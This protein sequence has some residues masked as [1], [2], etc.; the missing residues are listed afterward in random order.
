VNITHHNPIPG[1][2]KRV[3]ILGANGF[4]ARALAQSLA[5][6]DIP[7]AVIGSAQVDLLAPDA[8]GKLSALLKPDDALVIT[9]ALTPEKGKDVRTFMKNITMVE[10]VCAALD[11]VRCSQ[12]IYLSSDAVYDDADPLVRETT[13]RTGL[14]LYGLMHVAREQ[15]LGFV[16]A[17]KTPIPLCLVRPCAIYGA[18]DTHNSY[19]P[20]RFMRTALKER[21]ITMF[22]QGEEQ[23][24]HVY[25]SDVIRFL[26]ACLRHR[27]EG[28]V[29]IVSGQSVSFREVAK[30]I[31]K[32]SAQPVVMENLTRGPGSI[33]THRHFDV[34]LRLRAFPDFHT[35]P[36]ETGLAESWKELAGTGPA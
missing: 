21:K 3:V 10:Q 17:G 6:A 23:R 7:F 36:L 26:L 28:A 4:V 2:P 8:A 32:L 25:I 29:N 12:V 20:N 11:A 27:S 30:A 5:D 19:S 24:D 13:P 22:G 18:G 15:M 16:A 33:I 1:D 14:G 35:T 31:S 9:S 34:S